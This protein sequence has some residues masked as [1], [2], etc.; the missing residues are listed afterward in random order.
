MVKS[1]I[2]DI[3]PDAVIYHNGAIVTAGDEIIARE[4]IEYKT[5]KKILSRACETLND[6]NISVEINDVLYANFDVSI[7]WAGAVAVM[8][9]FDGLPHFDAD[10]II[11][12]TADKKIIGEIENLLPENLYTAVSENFLCMVMNKNAKKEIGVKRVAEHFDFVNDEIVSFGDDYNDVGMI[13]ACGTG[14]AVENAIAE[15]KNAAKHVCGSNEN[16]GVAKWIE[17]NIL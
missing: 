3:V 12:A 5:V 13:G 9:N 7:A 6:L 8:E 10:K 16:D 11:F 4:G 17:E 14:V 15:A 2:T 1:K